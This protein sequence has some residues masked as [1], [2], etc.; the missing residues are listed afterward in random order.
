MNLI[1]TNALAMFNIYFLNASAPADV[2]A[3]EP[4]LVL[5]KIGGLFASIVSG[6][7]FIIIVKNVWDLGP[8]I[9]QNDSS[10]VNS[11]IRGIAGGAIMAFIT[12]ILAYLGFTVGTPGS[13]E[14]LGPVLI[15]GKIGALFSTIV[16]GTGI[17][18]VVKNVMDLGPAIQQN[19]SSA[20]NNSVRGIAGG[21]IM[22]FVTGIL[23]FL[24]FS[25]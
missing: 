10:T 7:G 19:D 6:I 3:L 18:V 24:G 17:I 9:Q 5:G 16:S 20:V 1:V 22:A 2:T 11:A 25:A 23:A 8:A 21:A 15:L 14:N 13:V 4:V 12:S